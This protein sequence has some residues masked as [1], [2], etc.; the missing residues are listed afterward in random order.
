MDNRY[1]I[2]ELKGQMKIVLA[3]MAGLS[4]MLGAVMAKLLGAF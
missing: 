1:Q 4:A 2:G 3:F